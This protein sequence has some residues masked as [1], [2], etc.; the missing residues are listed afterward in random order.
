MSEEL[1]NLAAE[2][3]QVEAGEVAA[4]GVTA[5]GVEVAAPV[6]PAEE[7]KT[8]TRMAAG[9]VLSLVPEIKPDWTDEKLDAFGEA[10][11]RCAQHYG[12]SVGEVVGHPL[13]AL[14][15]AGFPLAVPVWKLK[16]V[17]EQ[18]KRGELPVNVPQA[19]P[20]KAGND[21]KTGQVIQLG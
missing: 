6:D 13:L 8:A 11:G 20:E 4:S 9:M 7:W 15:I 21:G 3:A 10:L 19:M 17:K 18:K 16:Q 5:D 1:A 14:A 2:A 12:W